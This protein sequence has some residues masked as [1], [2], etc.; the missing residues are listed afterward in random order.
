MVIH[1]LLS[2]RTTFILTDAV[3]NYKKREMT[4]S[5]ISPSVSGHMVFNPDCILI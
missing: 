2:T 3:T 1:G 5:G 4:I